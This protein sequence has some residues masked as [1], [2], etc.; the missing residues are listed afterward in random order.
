MQIEKRAIWD[1]ENSEWT[2]QRSTLT[3]N[4]LRQFRFPSCGPAIL[5]ANSPAISRT[6]TKRENIVNFDFDIPKL[7]TQARAE[8]NANEL[9]LDSYA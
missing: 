4:R 9:S 2:I 5:L 1:E 3:G 8:R 6:T 7:R